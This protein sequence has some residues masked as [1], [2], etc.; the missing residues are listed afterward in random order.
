MRE[1]EKSVEGRSK[2]IKFAPPPR[3]IVLIFFALIAGEFALWVLDARAI[4]DGENVINKGRRGDGSWTPTFQVETSPRE[5]SEDEA[6]NQCHFRS[7]GH[8]EA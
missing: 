5:E 3:R 1:R 2:G 7:R 8:N 4:N 6:A